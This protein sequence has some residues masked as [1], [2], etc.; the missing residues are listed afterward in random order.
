M[1]DILGT[2]VAVNI[3]AA[4]SGTTGTGL[5]LITPWLN[6]GIAG[7]LI[8]MFVLR[9][10]IVPEWV[11]RAAEERHTQECAAFTARIEKLEASLKDANNLIVG[12]VIPALTRSTDVNQRYVEEI[13][14][15]ADSLRTELRSHRDG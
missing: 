5:D 11:L 10:G 9:K 6:I 13:S 15:R 12:Q 4:A 14:V 3:A 7:V 2:G 1:T 8:L